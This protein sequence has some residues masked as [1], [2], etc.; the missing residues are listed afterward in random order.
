MG[1]FRFLFQIFSVLSV[2]IMGVGSI[3]D[4]PEGSVS[5]QQKF[6]LPSV[7]YNSGSL[8]LDSQIEVQERCYP[9]KFWEYIVNEA[10]STRPQALPSAKNITS[11]TFMGERRQHPNLRIKLNNILQYR[12]GEI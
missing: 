1:L 11:M 5:S 4:L 12:A 8:I 3:I 2:F 9:S 10:P 6:L 7:V